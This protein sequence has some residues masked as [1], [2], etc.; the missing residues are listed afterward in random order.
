[1]AIK[2]APQ[3]FKVLLLLIERGGTLVRREEL[4]Q[5]VW[6]MRPS[7]TLSTVS[8]PASAVGS[9]RRRP[10]GRASSDCPRL[11]YRLMADTPPAVP[12]ETS[13]PHPRSPAA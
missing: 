6:G 13:A 11:G 10:R 3:P 5:A 9:P 1:M 7:S 8:T 2:L 4:R 12:A